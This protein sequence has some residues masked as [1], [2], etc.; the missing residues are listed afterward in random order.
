[1][2]EPKYVTDYGVLIELFIASVVKRSPELEH[3]SFIKKIQNKLD[4]YH[5][6]RL[7]MCAVSEHRIRVAVGKAEGALKDLPSE[8]SIG[9][10]IWLIHNRNR[11]ILKP[12][13][14]DV[15]AFENMNKYFQAQG[16][17][18]ATAKVLNKIEEH[19]YDSEDNPTK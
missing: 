19:M 7:A 14:F 6:R 11:E 5:K 12:Y 2:K 17:I 3:K 18:M 4:R 10:I 16:V 9:A 1:M 13:D 8:I 15:R